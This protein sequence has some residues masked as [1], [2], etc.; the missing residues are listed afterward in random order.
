L[1]RAALIVLPFGFEELRSARRVLWF[2]KHPNPRDPTTTTTSSSDRRQGLSSDPVR[3]KVI[4]KSGC[5]GH[6]MAPG[7]LYPFL[8]NDMRLYPHCFP[9]QEEQAQAENRERD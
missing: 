6:V 2:H 5:L 7:H 8:I 4:Y 1:D 3:C 9:D